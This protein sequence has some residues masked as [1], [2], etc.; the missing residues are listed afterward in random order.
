MLISAFSGTD[1]Y[2]WG[3][4]PTTLLPGYTSELDRTVFQTFTRYSIG[5][6]KFNSMEDICS[7]TLS[8]QMGR[9]AIVGDWTLPRNSESW[10]G[11]V[12]VNRAG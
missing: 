2:H 10:G 7:S 12:R 5:F 8:F 6:C 4:S 1:F 11:G 9:L 3:R